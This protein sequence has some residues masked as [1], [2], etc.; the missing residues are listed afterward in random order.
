MHT[1]TEIWFDAFSA[2]QAGFP[3]PSTEVLDWGAQDRFGI[4]VREP[5]GALG[6]G[7]LILLAVAAFYEV[8]GRDR[9]NGILYPEIYLFHVGQR[10]G[11]H[12]SLDF[13]PERKEILVADDA[14]AVLAAINAAGITHLAVPDR[15]PALL[16][17]V[18]REPESAQDR[19][20]Q[21]FAYCASG[22]ANDSDLVLATTS[23]EVISN[24][25]FTLQPE[26]WLPEFEVEVA[27]MAGATPY[28]REAVRVV[29]YMHAREREI[30][31]DDPHYLAARE[32]VA[33]AVASCSITESYRRIDVA[34]AI[35]MLG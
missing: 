16:A 15:P 28:E 17:H 33:L 26:T 6:A 14:D 35:A 34:S 22:T 12:S 18:H 10:W 9:R 13:W 7:L 4:V 21:A 20:K 23:M 30:A 29:D 1:A 5:F 3:V 2:E 25:G 11:D 32:R 24:Y 8:P 27:A 19:V 31:R